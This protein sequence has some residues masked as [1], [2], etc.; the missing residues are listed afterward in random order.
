MSRSSLLATVATAALLGA[1][2]RAS[3]VATPRGGAPDSL[4][5]RRDIEYLASPALGGRLTGTSGNDEAARYLSKR[6]E[7]L[8]LVRPTLQSFVARPP[9]HGGASPSLPTQNVFAILPGTDPALRSQYV[10]IGAHFERGPPFDHDPG[11]RLPNP[12]YRLVGRARAPEVQRQGVALLH[13]DPIVDE[14]A[15]GVGRALA[16]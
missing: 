4:A 15:R 10:V 3:T 5:I 12:S 14:E 6:Y 9:A 8:G 2:G 16:S 1:C 13:V 11:A 7:S